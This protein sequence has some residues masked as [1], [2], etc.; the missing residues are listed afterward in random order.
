MIGRG[1]HRLE[2]GMTAISFTLEQL[3]AAPPEVRAWMRQQ[4]GLTLATLAELDAAPAPQTAAQPA[5]QQPPR[6]PKPPKPII[7]PQHAGTALPLRAAA[8]QQPL[9]T[10]ALP[11]LPPVAPAPFTPASKPDAAAVA[12][13][14]QASGLVACS[15]EEAVAI[16]N[17][18]SNDVLAAQVFFEL[19]RDSADSRIAPPLHAFAIADILR[20]VR[21][22]DSGQL[23]HALALI[24]GAF[25]HLRASQAVSLFAV[26]RA[27][28]IFVHEGTHR[29]ILLLW[30]ELM[31]EQ[32]RAAESGANALQQGGPSALA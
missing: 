12:Q 21:L 13:Q 25:Q 5:P 30:H 28:H 27:G 32:A 17:L 16:F 31:A 7:T 23:T 29:S 26:D 6:P 18:L 19:G 15:I 22:T 20:H 11:H 14:Q 10:A 4:L 1:F 24:N 3:R 2:I 9:L 8:M